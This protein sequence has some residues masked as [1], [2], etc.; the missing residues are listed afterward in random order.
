[1]RLASARPNEPLPPIG[2]TKDDE[3]EWEP[4]PDADAGPNE[5]PAGG[6]MGLRDGLEG[7]LAKPGKGAD[8]GPGELWAKP[9]T[10]MSS[11]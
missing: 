7:F 11:G 8:I 2:P 1:M 6:V 3:R 5:G 10:L 4:R 9:R